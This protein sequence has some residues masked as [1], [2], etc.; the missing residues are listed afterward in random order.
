LATF[1]MGLVLIYIYSVIHFTGFHGLGMTMGEFEYECAHLLPCWL[2][3][4]TEGLSDGPQFDPA[5]VGSGNSYLYAFN[6]T[7][8][9]LIVLVLMA[10]ITGIIIDTFSAKRIMSNFIENDIKNRCFMCSITRETF[11]INNLS[12]E[13][14]IA[15]EH[16]MWQYLFYAIYLKERPKLLLNG[17]EQYIKKMLLQKKIDWLP[18][19]RALALVALGEKGS[20]AKE[21]VQPMHSSTDVEMLKAQVT[22]LQNERISSE[23]QLN[24]LL[25]E[26][27]AC[28]EAIQRISNSSLVRK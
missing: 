15:E 7:Y 16:N 5:D 1:C 11:E 23:N 14:H 28:K 18:N 20:A 19:E 3:Y 10:L 2:T 4:I 25:K 22:S 12:F 27:T 13:H 26:V 21:S 9:F 17:T 8:Y 6:I 24:N